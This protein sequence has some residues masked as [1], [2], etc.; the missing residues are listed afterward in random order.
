MVVTT[1]RNACQRCR[2]F[3]CQHDNNATA[4]SQPARVGL[5]IKVPSWRGRPR[6]LRHAVTQAFTPRGF[7]LGGRIGPGKYNL[8]YQFACELVTGKKMSFRPPGLTTDRVNVRF[9]LAEPKCAEERAGASALY[10]L[11]GNDDLHRFH[12]HLTT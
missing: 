4:D 8:G 9:G 2:V 7:A 1:A 5:A 10:G 3:F 6:R 12:R 11:N